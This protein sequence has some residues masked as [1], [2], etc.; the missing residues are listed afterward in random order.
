VSLRFSCAVGCLTACSK[1]DS[2]E[3]NTIKKLYAEI[4]RNEATQKE[5]VK[6]FP[7]PKSGEIQDMQ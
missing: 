5:I 4:I 6:E 7:K 2:L 1:G 3:S